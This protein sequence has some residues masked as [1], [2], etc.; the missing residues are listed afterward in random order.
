MCISGL[1]KRVSAMPTLVL[2]FLH[3]INFLFVEVMSLNHRWVDQG[4]RLT[5]FKSEFLRS[6]GFTWSKIAILLQVSRSTLYRRLEEKGIDPSSSY[7]S[8]SNSQLDQEVWDIKQHHPNNGEVLIA[9]NLLSQGIRVQ[10]SR[11]RAS[12]H[13]VDLTGV[14]T[15]RR[16][17]V[18]RRVYSVPHPNYIWHIDGTHKLIRWRLVIHG[19]IDGFS[20][21]VVYLK[22]S[23]NNRA[24]TA[25][26]S[27]QQVVQTFGV[28]LR[29]RSDHGGENIDIWDYMLHQHNNPFS[30]I[31]G[32]STHNERVE[33]LWHDV[34]RCVTTP[35]A[36]TFYELEA[37]GLLDQLNEDDVFCLHNIFLPR[38]NQ[39]LADFQESWN[40]HT[41]SPEHSMTA[42]QLFVG[43]FMYT[44]QHNFS[45]GTGQTTMPVPATSIQFVSV[46]PTIFTP[47]LHSNR[48]FN[49]FAQ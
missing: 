15:R 24:A 3:W 4:R 40:H 5:F 11:L 42:I 49:K 27:F 39:C 16:F 26:T 45:E 41:I 19:A 44:T 29:I 8:I 21:S 30:V 48:V 47:V 18:Q 10:R 14:E 22:C 17:T 6:I 35:F 2:L 12:I 13:M 31:T 36:N 33:R 9:A 7:G 38:I 28:P 46:P 1:A 25:F 32:S 37:L 43:G 23:N 20:R 34:N